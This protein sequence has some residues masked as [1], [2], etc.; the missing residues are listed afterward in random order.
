MLL[1]VPRLPLVSTDAGDGRD[2]RWQAE[3][4]VGD[5]VDPAIRVEDV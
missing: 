2:D 5:D 4:A 3:D 1:A